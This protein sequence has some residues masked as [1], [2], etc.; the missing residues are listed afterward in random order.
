MLVHIKYEFSNLAS[1]LEFVYEDYHVVRV[2]S[3]FNSWS[4]FERMALP[5]DSNKDTRERSFNFLTAVLET[6]TNPCLQVIQ[7]FEEGQLLLNCPNFDSLSFLCNGLLSLAR[8]KIVFHMLEEGVW[9]TFYLTQDLFA[10]AGFI[11]E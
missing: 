2:E 5:H 3:V 10:H 1:L 9:I 7:S 6:V 4:K 8:E 11:V